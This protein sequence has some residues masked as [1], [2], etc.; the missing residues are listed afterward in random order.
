[1]VIGG[2][3]EPRELNCLRAGDSLTVTLCRTFSGTLID[4]DRNLGFVPRLAHSWTTSADGHTVTF[5]LR[6]DVLWQDGEPFTSKDVLYTVEKIRNPDSAIMGNLPAMFGPL[7][8]I[9]APDEQTVIARYGEPYILAY[10]AWAKAFIMPSHL[11]FAPGEVTPLSRA[12]I[13]TGPFRVAR[14]DAGVQIV[15]EANERYYDGRPLLDRLIY[16]IVPD[17]RALMVALRTGDIDVAGLSPTEAPQDD[18]GLPFR[19]VRYPANALNFIVWNTRETPGIFTDPR[20]R[21]ALSL[22]LDR[23]RYIDDITDGADLPAVST[24]HP[25]SWAH[26]PELGALPHDPLEA[27]RLLDEAGWIDGDGDGRRESPRG[28]AA[29][30]LLY[31]SGNPNDESL[32]VLFQE[33]LASLGVGVTLQAMDFPTLREKVRGRSFEAAIYHWGL[34]ADPDPFDFFHSGEAGSG[35]NLGGYSN[36]EVDR[37][38]EEGRRTMQ[39]DRRAAIYHEVERILIAEQPYSFVS[40]PVTAIGARRRVNGLDVGP[41]GFWGWYPAPLRWWVE[42]G[43]R[44]PPG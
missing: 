31:N 42:P 37:L 4:Y 39:V 32:G 33:S 22:A 19:V 44:L 18:S 41:A 13:G 14:W 35:Q 21:R 27:A 24:F 1:M 36:P 2:T 34:D 30:T 17:R 10:Q 43:D 11:P 12:P 28:R 8:E 29:F 26:D 7:A 40:H 5:T 9:E 15:M 23:Q 6:D 25:A 38:V 3:S 20:V 16:R